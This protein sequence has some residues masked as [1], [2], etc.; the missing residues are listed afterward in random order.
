[1]KKRRT[2]LQNTT[3]QKVLYLLAVGVTLGLSRSP[4]QHWHILKSI[5]KEFKAINRAYLYRLI[6][7][8]H[9][10]RLVDWRENDDGTILITITEAGK[11]RV[12]KFDPENIIIPSQNNWDEKWR[13]VIYD[14]PDKKR[15]A[16]NALR[17]KLKEM[18]FKE[19]QK[20]VF[21]HPFPCRDQ[22]DFI[23]EFFDLRPYVRYAEVI[24]P[25]NESELKLHFKLF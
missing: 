8:F 24:E 11:L 1:M 17:D 21:I 12:N 3:K 20:S 19:W 9:H 22:V 2:R 5:P 15:V 23:V 4:K 16:R 7:E 14:I 10:E 25:T 6:K 13:M 18:G